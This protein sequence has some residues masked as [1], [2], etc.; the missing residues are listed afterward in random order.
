M[1]L[2]WLVL[3]SFMGVV[4]G[5]VSIVWLSQKTIDI[6]PHVVVVCLLLCCFCPDILHC[7]YSNGFFQFWITLLP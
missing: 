6:T 2:S 3:L 7:T 1:A 5:T 4:S